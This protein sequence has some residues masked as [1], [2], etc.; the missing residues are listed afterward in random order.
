MKDD[1]IFSQKEGRLTAHIQC[2]IDHHT[3]KR[4]REKIDSELFEKRPEVLILDFSSVEF[5]DSS[6]LG[7][8]LGRVEKANAIGATVA[9]AGLSPALM[10]LVRLSGIE[11]VHGLSVI[12]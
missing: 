3:A 6:G 9:L 11:K 1:V 4:M 5:M 2:D 7:L 8:M 12:R 10:K